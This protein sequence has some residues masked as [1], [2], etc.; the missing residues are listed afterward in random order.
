MLRLAF[1]PTDR[2]PFSY[3]GSG[4]G[5]HSKPGRG[6]GWGA[7]HA[8]SVLTLVVGMGREQTGSARILPVRLAV[9]RPAAM[10]PHDPQL[11][12]QRLPTGAAPTGVDRENL[13]RPCPGLGDVAVPPWSRSSF[14]RCDCAGILRIIPGNVRRMKDM[15]IA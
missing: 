14:G 8:R 12:L 11:L 1:Q 3:A 6:L 10:A 9:G 13:E 5:R 4:G 7:T 2:D 15:E